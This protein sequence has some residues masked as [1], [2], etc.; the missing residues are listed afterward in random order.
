MAN[1]RRTVRQRMVAALR[2]LKDLSDLVPSP[3]RETALAVVVGVL[4]VPWAAVLAVYESQPAHVAFLAAVWA[5][6]AVAFFTWVALWLY[7]RLVLLR[8]L[9]DAEHFLATGWP[10]H[11]ALHAER[12]PAVLPGRIRAVDEWRQAMHAALLFDP[13]LRAFRDGLTDSDPAR[14]QIAVP[15]QTLEEAHRHLLTYL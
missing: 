1:E 11:A 3:Y 10:I 6:A 7:W 2:A 12:D 5:L 4:A 14:D 13:R 9:R 8:L 15:L